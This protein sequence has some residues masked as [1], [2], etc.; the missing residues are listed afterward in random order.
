MNRSAR[1]IVLI[2]AIPLL[3]SIGVSSAT[4][5]GS[6][7]AAPI[8]MGP[9]SDPNWKPAGH[10]AGPTVTT[11]APFSDL[12]WKPPATVGTGP[13]GQTKPVGRGTDVPML[14]LILGLVA[15]AAGI[16]AYAGTLRFKRMR[17]ASGG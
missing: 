16:A 8:S 3:L 5:L 11:R 13:V 6:H 14:G 2:A 12:N 7:H 9:F 4:A 10:Q 1:W 17:I 15:L